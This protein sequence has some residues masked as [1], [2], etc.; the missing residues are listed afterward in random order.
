MSALK[1]MVSAS[2]GSASGFSP[3][4]CFG[5]HHDAAPFRGFVGQRRHQGRLGQLLF[6][7]PAHRDEGHRLPVAV[8]DGAGLVEQQHVDVA[9]RLDGPAGEGDDVLLEE[10]VHP[11]DADGGQQRGDGRRRQADEERH[12]DGQRDRRPLPGRLDAVDRS[13]PNINLPMIMPIIADTN[14]L[15]QGEHLHNKGKPL[16]ST[17]L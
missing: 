2:A 9:G 8:G 7:V 14:T 11:G 1:A 6:A 16:R 10:P 13:L 5:Q 15:M 4:F 12:Q 17:L 3:Y